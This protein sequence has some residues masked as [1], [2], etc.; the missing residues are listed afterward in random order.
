MKT[1]ARVEVAF[2]W[3]ALS[4]AGPIHVEDG[5][6]LELDAGAMELDA[7]DARDG[8]PDAGMRVV[9][10]G[11]SLDAGA[12]DDDAG[13]AFDAG[14][15]RDA[16]SIRPAVDSGVLS[17]GGL[18]AWVTAHAVWEWFEIPN[19]ALSSVDPSPRPLGNT[20]PSSKISTWNGAALKESGSVYMLGAAGGHQDYVGNEVDEL[21][22]NVATPRWVQ[23]RAPS[24]N[25]DIYNLS[26][27][28]ADLRPAASH[29]Y[30]ST[31]Y[32]AAL[33]RMFILSFGGLNGAYPAPPSSFAYATRHFVISYDRTAGEWDRPDAPDA[34]D[35]YPAGGDN[36][37]ALCV[38]NPLT[39]KL[40]YS[41]SLNGFWEFDP[42]KPRGSQ[43]TRLHQNALNGNY[44]SGALDPV[45]LRLF[46]VGSYERTRPPQVFDVTT[47]QNITSTTPLGG[48]GAGALSPEPYQGVCFDRVNDAFLVFHNTDPISFHVVSGAQLSVSTQATTGTPPAARPNGIHNAVQYVPE[49]RGVVLANRHSGNVY[50]MRTAP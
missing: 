27:Y 1:L 40:Y 29:T 15:L 47:G 5:G 30:T 12:L 17:D 37:A 41:R 14:G 8:G 13:Q 11:G 22:L 48:L 24:A 26:A 50:F 18:P 7:G 45:R 42:R 32:H 23:V 33:N 4:C 20:G 43:W 44:V 9:D 49:L 39:G 31:H 2:C 46:A 3:L 19:T 38:S 35:P 6:L 10:G 21:A 25:A 34:F 36:I 16:G 28:Y